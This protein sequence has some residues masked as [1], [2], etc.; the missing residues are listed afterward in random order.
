MRLPMEWNVP[1]QSDGEFVPQ[2]IRHAS[3]HFAGGLV[4]EREQQD[5]VGRN[6]LF[7]QVGHAIGER[8]RLA[9]ARAGDDERRAGRRGDGGALLLVEFARVI[10]LQVNGRLKRLQDVIARHLVN[11]TGKPWPAKE[12]SGSRIPKIPNADIDKPVRGWDSHCPLVASVAQLVEQLTLNQLVPG[13]SPGRGTMIPFR[14]K[15]WRRLPDQV[16]SPR[17]KREGGKNLI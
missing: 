2:Q 1:P 13:S 11:S 17:V 6:A 3:H 12:K 10:N 14:N 9:R 5:A 15:C 8:A 4:G 7:E 16:D